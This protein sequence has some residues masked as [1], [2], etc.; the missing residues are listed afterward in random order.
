MTAL[1]L[2]ARLGS[3]RLPGK[4]LLDLGGRPVLA[5]CLEALQAVEADLRVVATDEASRP[6][7]APWTEAAGWE[8][9]AGA[10]DD[11]LDR[12]VQVARRWSATTLVRATGD[13][14]L[15]SAAQA[16]RLVERHRDRGS[17]YSGF[18]GGPLGTGVEVLAVAALERAWSGSPDAYEREHVSPFLLRRPEVFHID[19]PVLDGGQTYPEGRVTLDT[20][21]D[22]G[23]LKALWSDLYRGVALTTEE[24]IPWLKS[25]PR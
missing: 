16:N 6:A 20:A 22:Y 25:H 18:Q 12:F 19:R 7:F 11:V 21:E 13:N 5:R 17:D 14:P 10:A 23:Y 3:Q 2:Q 9:F 15:V 4:A 8:L 1:V 24:L